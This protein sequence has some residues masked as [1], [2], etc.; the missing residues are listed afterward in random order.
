MTLWLS[1]NNGTTAVRYLAIEMDP[2]DSQTL[3][4]GGFGDGVIKTTNGGA[5]WQT[6]NTGLTFHNVRSLTIDPRN[7]LNIYAGTNA[8][9]TPGTYVG[10]IWGA[11]TDLPVPADYDGDGRTDIA[12][13]RPSSGNWFV[14]PSTAPGNYSLTI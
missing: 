4:A 14:L 6:I 13:W 1:A 11:A 8:S 2:N 5:N 10:T 3:Y 9:G 12:V 7:S